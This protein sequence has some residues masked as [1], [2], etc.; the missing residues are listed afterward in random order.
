MC[1]A[2]S[3]YNHD[4][5]ISVG[6]YQYEFCLFICVQTNDKYEPILSDF[7]LW[8]TSCNFYDTLMTQSI[9]IS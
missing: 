7:C 6:H 4:K 8:T 3:S 2:E 5:N 9:R 1:G